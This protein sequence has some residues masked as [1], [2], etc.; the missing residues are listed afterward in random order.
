M[1]RKYDEVADS[2]S[3][4]EDEYG[5][6]GGD[7]PLAEEDL[8]ENSNLNGYDDTPLDALDGPEVQPD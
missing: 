2:E 6:T 8:L 5:W 4:E 7:D 1:K 3:E